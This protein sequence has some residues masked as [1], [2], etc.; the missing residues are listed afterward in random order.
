VF[1]WDKDTI[2]AL[3]RW[4]KDGVTIIC[5]KQLHMV[6]YLLELGYDLMLDK[7]WNMSMQPG[8]KK[9]GLVNRKKE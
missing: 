2:D 9:F 8:Y 1:T 5:D 7:L 3:D 4:E 6:A